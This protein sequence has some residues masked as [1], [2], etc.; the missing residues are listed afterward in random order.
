[1]PVSASITIQSLRSEQRRLSDG[2]IMPRL[3]QAMRGEWQRRLDRA[4][5]QSVQELGHT[6]VSE[7]YRMACRGNYR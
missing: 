1:M 3:W 7:D 6:G 2:P 5:A 4:V